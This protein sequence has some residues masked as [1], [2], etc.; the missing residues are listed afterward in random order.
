LAPDDLTP[1]IASPLPDPGGPILTPDN[2]VPPIPDVT[3]ATLGLGPVTCGTWQNLN[4]W[5]QQNPVMAVVF[6]ASAVLALDGL[7]QLLRGKR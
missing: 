7:V 3:S 1:P 4:Q 6:L 5:I 2:I